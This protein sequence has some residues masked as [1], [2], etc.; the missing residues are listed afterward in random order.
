MGQDFQELIKK[1]PRSA[2]ELMMRII[3]RHYILPFEISKEINM[4]LSKDFNTTE[5]T[6][7]LSEK[8]E[9]NPIKDLEKLSGMFSSFYSITN[10]LGLKLSGPNL[11]MDKYE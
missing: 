7:A 4:I 6:L 8:N 11:D 9:I 5:W 1:Q 3:Y 2:L 10:N